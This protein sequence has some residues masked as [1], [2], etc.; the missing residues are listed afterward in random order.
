MSEFLSGENEPPPD[1]RK[2]FKELIRQWK[3]YV[4]KK[5]PNS[6]G[7]IFKNP[8]KEFILD[9]R[10]RMAEFGV[11]CTPKEVAALIKLISDTLEE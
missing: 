1:H 4:R 3:K 7:D 2:N 6:S 11:E 9:Q 10:N 8:T 5:W